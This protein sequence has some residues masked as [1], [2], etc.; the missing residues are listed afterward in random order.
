M[1]KRKNPSLYSFVARQ[2]VPVY[3]LLSPCTLHM[4]ISKTGSL[5]DKGFL[6]RLGTTLIVSIDRTFLAEMEGRLQCQL[7]SMSDFT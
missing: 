6:E 3:G 1:I 2:N 7:C 5:V 4:N